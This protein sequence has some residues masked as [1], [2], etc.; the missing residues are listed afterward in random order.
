MLTGKQDIDGVVE[1]HESQI[2]LRRQLIDQLHRC[3][4][5]FLDFRSGHRSG[6]IDDHG[7]VQRQPIGPSP[8]LRFQIDLDHDLLIFADRDQPSIG[9][10]LKIESCRSGTRQTERQDNA[11]PSESM[12]HP[13]LWRGSGLLVSE[14]CKC[15]VKSVSGE[16]WGR[17][18]VSA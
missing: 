1:L 13:L 8:G 9:I 4:F 6:V 18:D 2:V 11:A 5:G 12:F 15:S 16:A 3:L 7:Q 14:R 17:G 10:Q